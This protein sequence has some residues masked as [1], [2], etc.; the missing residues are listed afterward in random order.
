[1]L[2]IVEAPIFAR[3]KVSVQRKSWALLAFIKRAVVGLQDLFSIG[4][5]HGASEWVQAKYV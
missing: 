5:L 3:T 4:A 2:D 1:M